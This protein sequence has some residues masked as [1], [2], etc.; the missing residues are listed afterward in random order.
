[1][2]TS[3]KKSWHKHHIPHVLPNDQPSSPFPDLR[4]SHAHPNQTQLHQN[5]QSQVPPRDRDPMPIVCDSPARYIF[6]LF[7]EG[8]TPLARWIGTQRLVGWFG[9]PSR[10]RMPINSVAFCSDEPARIGRCV[11]LRDLIAAFP[12]EV[13]ARARRSATPRAISA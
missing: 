6:P 9:A 1:M 10:S 3:N 2:S 5:H 8:S 12:A 4:S 11:C 7:L 13:A